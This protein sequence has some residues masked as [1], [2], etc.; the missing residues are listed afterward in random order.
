MNQTA[1]HG[2]VETLVARHYAQPDLEG[3]ILRAL[4]AAGKDPDRLAASDLA[5]V[6]EF[7][8]GGRDATIA[9]ADEL[10]FE[11][12]MRILDVGCGIG[13]A[14]RFFGE[15]GCRVVGV[16]VTE[17]FIRTAEALTRRVG[18]SD[19]VEFETGSALA[20]PFESGSFDGAYMMHVGMN[21]EDKPA[22]FSEIRRVLKKG[23]AF[24]VY[25][26]TLTGKG[27][28]TFP[29]PCALDADTCFMV[30]AA[31]YRRAIESAAFEVE[32]E[33]DRTEA[34]RAF[35]RREMELARSGEPSPLGIHILLGDAAPAILPNVVRQFEE[36]V[37]APIELF[38]RA[39]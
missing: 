11:E 19:R 15:R 13:G 12:G 33:R 17:E 34:A 25:D 35:F 31:D 20:L 3:K 6:D 10:G 24:G 37:F 30:S 4:A 2:R 18:L 36:G 16:D 38:S 26:V 39:R 14:A 23:S 32:R 7:H 5:P 9:F 28:P 1:A 29:L 8:T 22:L 27:P 21:V